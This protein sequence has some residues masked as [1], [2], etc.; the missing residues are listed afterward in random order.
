MPKGPQSPHSL[1]L[2]P[3]ALHCSCCECWPKNMFEWKCL[4]S[5][6]TVS[7]LLLQT[8]CFF[9]Q[10]YQTLWS[11]NE[12]CV[13]QRHVWTMGVKTPRRL[14]PGYH[15]KYYVFR[16]RRFP[17]PQDIMWAPEEPSANTPLRNGNAKVLKICSLDWIEDL[18]PVLMCRLER[19]WKIYIPW[20]STPFQHDQTRVPCDACFSYYAHQ[21]SNHGM[22]FIST[23]F[24]FSIFMWPPA[25]PPLPHT[26]NPAGS[27]RH[28]RWD[29]QRVV[30]NQK[31]IVSREIQRT[32]LKD[33]YKSLGV[34][35]GML[36]RIPYI[37]I[38]YIPP[39][40]A[41][42]QNHL[43]GN[44]RGTTPIHPVYIRD[45]HNSWTGSPLFKQTMILG[46]SQ[47]SAV[48]RLRYILRFGT[49]TS[50]W[51]THTHLHTHTYTWKHPEGKGW[52]EMKWECIVPRAGFLVLPSC[53]SETIGIK[54]VVA[55]HWSQQFCRYVWLIRPD[56]SPNLAPI[57]WVTI[58]GRE[59]PRAVDPLFQGFSHTHTHSKNKDFTNPF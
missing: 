38:I 48:S 16:A 6:K 19:P 39:A 26:L 43:V 51:Y 49:K 12:T 52:N 42:S 29:E 28:P 31:V 11:K 21:Y 35:L 20:L 54:L 50:V 58:Q 56:I 22:T 45:Y 44:Q 4:V 55:D 24:M 18:F 8:T 15:K 46:I 57:R 17:Q 2:P 41:V 10:T 7:I 25:S 40:W 3:A 32:L 36:G 47:R 14:V 30:T 33:H 23:I 27:R 34:N 13:E 9:L 59:W 53:H 5:G 1:R 37:L